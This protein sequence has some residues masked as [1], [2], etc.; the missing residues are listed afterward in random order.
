MRVPV[1]VEYILI[2]TAIVTVIPLG[3]AQTIFV[4]VTVFLLWL[5]TGSNAF[6]E[7]KDFDKR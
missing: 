7:G 2:L 4:A 6:K 5:V 1:F 3:V